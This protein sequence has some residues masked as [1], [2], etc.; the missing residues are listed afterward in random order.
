[1]NTSVSSGVLEKNDGYGKAI[2]VRAIV[3]IGHT[4]RPQKLKNL[5]RKTTYMATVDPCFSVL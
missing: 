4:K 3:L 2:D 1:L 5:S